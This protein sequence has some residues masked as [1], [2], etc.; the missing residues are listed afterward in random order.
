MEVYV[1]QSGEVK[2]NAT[3]KKHTATF[4]QKSKYC[5]YMMN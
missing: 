5:G 1:V 2:R 3:A 4:V